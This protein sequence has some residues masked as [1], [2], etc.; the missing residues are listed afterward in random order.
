[1]SE[2]VV[3]P[4][5]EQGSKKEQV[6]KMFDSISPKY[7]F[8][9]H[10]LSMGMDILWRRKAVQYLSKIQPKII[11]DIAT[12][13]GDFAIEASRL[14]PEKII[15]LDISEGMLQI[16]REKMKKNHLENIVSMLKGDS[17]N[18]PFDDHYADAITI[19]FGVRNFENLNKGLSEIYRVLK[20]GGMVVILEPAIPSKFPMKQLFNLYFK[21][22]LPFVGRWFS[23]DPSAYEYLPKSVE[24]F[25]N[26]KEFLAICHQN[27][28]INTEWKPLTFGIC[29]LYILRK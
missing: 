3:K 23:K 1:M 8:L 14:K 4:Y 11:L 16:G 26:G 13:T 24:A 10:F 9:N 22:I 27:H 2:S 28:F 6:E 29:S 15:G 17:E 20:P 25:P 19:G 12:G 18:L 5:N 21:K 7:D